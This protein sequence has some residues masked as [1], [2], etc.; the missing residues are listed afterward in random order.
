MCLNSI[1]KKPLIK[2]FYYYL[3]I[4]PTFQL[5]RIAQ[6]QEINIRNT[7][8]SPSILSTATDSHHQSFGSDISPPSPQNSER[9]ATTIQTAVIP[10]NRPGNVSFSLTTNGTVYWI[11]YTARRANNHTCYQLHM[12]NT[13]TL[14]LKANSYRKFFPLKY[15]SDILNSF[16]VVTK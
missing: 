4:Q 12:T 15:V 13:L 5:D 16:N 10:V 8:Q 1:E 2:Q 6:L 14:N 11:R 3:I 7:N 9:S